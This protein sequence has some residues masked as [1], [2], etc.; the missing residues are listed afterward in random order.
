MIIAGDF[1]T[2]Y[3]QQTDPAG[4]KS[5]R[6]LVELNSTFSQVDQTDISPKTEKYKFFSSTHEKFTQI[7][8][9]LGHETHLNEFKRIGI[10]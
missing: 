2:L 5:E 3:Q 6:S 4:R 9:I 10:I 8:Y 7:D 1:N